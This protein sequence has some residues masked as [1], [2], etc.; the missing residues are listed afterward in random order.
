M[1]IDPSIGWKI[2]EFADLANKVLLTA[3]INVVCEPENALVVKAVGVHHMR[4]F[5]IGPAYHTAPV[6]KT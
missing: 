4:I 6:K 3:V 1:V 5:E 2:L